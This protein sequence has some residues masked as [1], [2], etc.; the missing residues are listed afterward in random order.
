MEVS[1]CLRNQTLQREGRLKAINLFSSAL[2]HLGN[3]IR[4]VRVTVIDEN[5][6][7]G[8]VDTTC[9]AQIKLLDGGTVVVKERGDNI[10]KVVA[11][12]AE[13]AKEVLGRTHQRRLSRQRDR[14]HGNF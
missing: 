6:P 4:S 12:T 11:L 9:S 1:L 2:D 3:F 10:F 8:G 14:R 5:G 13:K 7:R